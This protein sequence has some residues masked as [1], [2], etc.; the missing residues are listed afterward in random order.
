MAGG[1]KVG[2]IVGHWGVPI[3]GLAQNLTGFLEQFPHGGDRQGVGH[4]GRAVLGDARGATVGQGTG[5]RH[6][7]IARINRTTRKHE[8]VRHEHRLGPT[9]PHQDAR[10]GPAVAQHDHGRG[11]ANLAFVNFCFGGHL[12]PS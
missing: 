7:I 9:L 3:A 4:I 1:G 6:V 8:L 5:Q 12:R 10:A 11:V 2:P